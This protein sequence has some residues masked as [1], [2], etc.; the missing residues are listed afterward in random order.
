LV[1]I[2][3]LENNLAVDAF[4][5]SHIEL[6]EILSTQIAI[7]LEN[8]SLYK[9]LEQKIAL[10]TQALSKKNEELNETLMSL[11]QTQKQL[12]ESEKL[13]SLGQLVAGVAH[14]INT[15]VGV[16]VTGASTLADET[17]KLV[18]LFQSGA[19]KRSDLENYVGT[20]ASVSKLLL[21]NMSRA[22]NLIQSFKSVAVDQASEEKRE[23]LMKAYLEEVL[24][25]VSPMLRKAGH[26]IVVDCQH[27]IALDTYPGAL[28]QIIT[29]LVMNTL[30]HAFAE[31]EQ[32]TISI[33]VREL[34]NHMLELRFADNGKGITADNL[35]KIF[36]PFFTTMRAKGGSGLGLSIVHNLVTGRLVGNIVVE[37]VEGQGTTFVLCFPTD[38]ARI[39]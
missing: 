29:N 2:L 18:G 17:A 3:Y 15:P 28:S 19:M 24:L 16:A 5:A 25:S 36:D 31:N 11:K 10:R 26:H 33:Q 8:A 6:L 21:S 35:P 13:A 38:P 23:F 4:T 20:A 9:G 37:S 7:A 1:G 14:E 22:A 12:V 30:T 32:G 39:Q 34:D 27:D